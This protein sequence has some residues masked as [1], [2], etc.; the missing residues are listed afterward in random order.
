MTRVGDRLERAVEVLRPQPVQPNPVVVGSVNG[1]TC[2]V[3]LLGD[4]LERRRIG[5]VLL[6]R[7]RAGDG[8]GLKRITET[9]LVTKL[10]HL[11][12]QGAAESRVI[13]WMDGVLGARHPMD[14]Y[15]CG[16]LADCGNGFV[17]RLRRNP[18]VFHRGSKVYMSPTSRSPIPW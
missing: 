9:G 14:R 13:V 7:Q 3:D 1:E 12:L 18:G 15:R 2:A 8:L 17:E 5:G 10:G 16:M 11:G 4:E 6:G